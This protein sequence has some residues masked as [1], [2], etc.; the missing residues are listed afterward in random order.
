MPEF[1][2]RFRSAEALLG[3]RKE[4]EN[5]EIYFAAPDQLND[6]VEGYKDIFWFGDA[7][8]WKNLLKHYLLCL[9]QVCALFIIGG[10]PRANPPERSTFRKWRQIFMQ[11]GKTLASLF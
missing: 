11:G 6:P 1:L 10:K 7:I 4:L 3:E 2:Y 9:E 5:Q 8:V